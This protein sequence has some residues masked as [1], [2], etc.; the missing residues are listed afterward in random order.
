MRKF[1][2]GKDV[3]IVGSAPC[4]LD[5]IGADIDGHEVVVRVNNYKTYGVN[6]I[7]QF[8][9]FRRYVGTKT[10][11]HYSYYGGAIRKTTQEM[12]IEGLKAHL[13]KCPNDICHLTEWHKRHGQIQGG[14]FRPIYRRREGYWERPV[15]VP[16]KA[17]YMQIFNILNQ[18]V[19]STGLAAIWEIITSNP[20]R[21][22]ITGFDFMA[23]GRHNVNERWKKGRAD[24]PVG[25]DFEAEKNLV[26]KWVKQ[27]DF[28]EVDDHLRRMIDNEN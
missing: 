23:S 25:H 16:L 1:F 4:V 12:I 9:D 5:N 24:D 18:H 13:C 7:G 19:P 10:D 11:Y 3:C 20:K 27:Y 2:R 15:Y 8:Y 14:D 17:H 6:R 21:V 26:M 28:I 22:F